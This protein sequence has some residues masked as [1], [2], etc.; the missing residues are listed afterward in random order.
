MKKLALLSLMLLASQANAASNEITT[1]LKIKA[2]GGAT[3]GWDVSGNRSCIHNI[4]YQPSSEAKWS[5]IGTPTEPPRYNFEIKHKPGCNAIITFHW[6][7]SP[8]DNDQRSD[9]FARV[10]MNQYR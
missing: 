7:G 9:S 3:P 1:V 4:S 5:N 6:D 10:E 2:W 8:N